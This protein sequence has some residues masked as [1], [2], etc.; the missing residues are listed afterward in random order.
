MQRLGD[1]L[2]QLA[3]YKTQW[4]SLTQTSNFG[5]SFEPPPASS[6]R[7]VETADF[8][9]NPGNLRMFSYVPPEVAESPALVVV[10]HGCTQNA[11]GYDYGSGWSVLAE[12]YGFIVIYPEQQEA[13]NIK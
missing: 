9:A 1:M 3:R 10:L 7:L 6:S 4:E 11:A 12:E 8:G 5:S 13:N 2:H